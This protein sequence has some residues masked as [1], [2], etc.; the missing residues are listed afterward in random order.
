MAKILAFCSYFDLSD[1][2]ASSTVPVV[3]I[4]AQAAPQAPDAAVSIKEES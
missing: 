1:E 4:A 3:F 2:A